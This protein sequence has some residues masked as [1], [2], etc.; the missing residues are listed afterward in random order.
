MRKITLIGSGLVGTLLSLYLA[1][2]GYEV[3]IYEARPDPRISLT[4]KGRS[5]NLAMSCRGLTSLTEIGLFETVKKLLVP[6]R[7][8]AIH[9][10][11][12]EIKY[13]SFGRHPEEYI[14]A[15]QRNE[16]NNLLLD[17][18]AKNP[19]IHQHFEM[20]TIDLDL[21]KKI[22]YF[23]QH[24]K[25]MIIHYELLIGAD[26]AS[27]FVRRTMSQQDKIKATRNFL[28][29]G[30][31]ELSISNQTDQHFVAEHLHLWPR[32]SY[33]LLGNPNTDDSIT[34]SL[35][36][37]QH[38]KNSFSELDSELKINQFFKESFPD[39]FEA[40]PDLLGEFL[41]HPTGNMSTIRC[42]PWHYQDHCLLIGDA[43]HGI[44]PFFGQGMNCGFEDCRVLDQLLNQYRDN[45][46]KV[47]PAFYNLRKPNTDAVS[48]MSM[49]NYHEI[50]TD[51][52]D[53]HFNLKKRLEQEL[54]HHYPD[55][56]VSKHVLV[57]FTNTPY[58]Q[59]QAIGVLQRELL[60][61]ICAST[62]EISNIDWNETDKLMD[63]YDK[64]L[65]NLS[66]F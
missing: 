37:P 64:K 59:A 30:Y 25:P 19:R 29:Y 20:K 44:V 32:D 21:D 9:E 57:M 33:L 43:A 42:E 26:G 55:V 62:R 52:R 3:D 35:F 6:M 48:M 63:Q 24:G 11:N 46:E 51:I 28:P 66:L 49:D 14:N 18:A 22:I 50:Q 39:A 15:V 31:K 27:S 45:W 54:M 12:G 1:R 53:E 56:Y 2:R 4:D 47:M 65:A 36:L 60:E 40:M 17:E 7:A 41:G 38:G 16:L 13:Q 58:A 34:G 61:T 10:Q 8:R 5:I 23:Q